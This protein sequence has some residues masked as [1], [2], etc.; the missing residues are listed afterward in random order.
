MSLLLLL[1]AGTSLHSLVPPFHPDAW[2]TIENWI[3]GGFS[4]VKSPEIVVAPPLSGHRGSAWLS[5]PIRKN[6]LAVDV[7]LTVSCVTGG[8]SFGIWLTAHYGSDGEVCGGPRSFRGIAVL[9]NVVTD[10]NRSHFLQL[11]AV[12][13]NNE[14][15]LSLPQEPFAVFP[16]SQSELDLTV[17]IRSDSTAFTILAVTSTRAGGK[18]EITHPNPPSHFYVGITAMNLRYFS[19]IALK[20]VKFSNLTEFSESDAVFAPLNPDPHVPFENPDKYLNPHLNL[21]QSETPDSLADSPGAN[22]SH[23]M[24]VIDELNSA[25]Y[26]VASYRE[27]NRY[28]QEN[29]RPYTDKW[30][31]RS[32]KV[33]FYSIFMS[34]SVSK[35]LK[36]NRNIF[37]AFNES[38]ESMTSRAR[39]NVNEVGNIVKEARTRSDAQCNASLADLADC[40]LMRG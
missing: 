1:A 30:Q 6:D 4:M 11:T 24:N 13:A 25:A 37:R 8:G 34:N 27:L 31:K 15:I 29:L 19:K 18:T 16:I 39:D 22:F 5:S 17:R 36:R 28:L 3:F 2:G 20:Y 10:A 35:L 23:L 7:S 33:L 26:E 21:I 14:D 32:I 9:G 12:S 38:V 40:V